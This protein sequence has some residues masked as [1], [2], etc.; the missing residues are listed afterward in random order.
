MTERLWLDNPADPALYEQLLGI[1]R[2]MHHH[3]YWGSVEDLHAAA[4]LVH[5]L[6]QRTR[7]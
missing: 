7:A 5:A 6:A 4:H 1:V 2:A 3:P